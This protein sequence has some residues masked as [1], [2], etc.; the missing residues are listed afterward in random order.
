MK[1]TVNTLKKA[2][3]L[4]ILLVAT[5]QISSAQMA[6][7]NAITPVA[8]IDFEVQIVEYGTIDQNSNG[9]RTVN[10]KNTGDAPLI[11][12]SVKSSCGCT[13]PSYEKKP[14]A[15]G[16]SGKITVKY[17]T[18]RV[19]AFNKTITVTSNAFETT[20]LLKIK[21]TVVATK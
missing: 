20:K 10:F 5:A 17:D 13:V 7:E 2:A 3:L 6:F 11:I 16:A 4:C 8:I 15:P 19:G 14:I 1:T 9:E 12:S 18:N 21:G